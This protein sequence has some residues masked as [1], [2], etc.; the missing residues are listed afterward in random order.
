M[1][2]D[3]SNASARDRRENLTIL[4]QVDRDA[5]L[6]LA[7]EWDIAGF[8]SLVVLEKGLGRLCLVSSGH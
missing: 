6:D 8:P 2:A 3:L 4:Y 5:Y 7:K 1:I